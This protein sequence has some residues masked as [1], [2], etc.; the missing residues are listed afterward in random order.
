MTG[1]RQRSGREGER[2]GGREGERAID[3]IRSWLRAPLRKDGPGN[4][5]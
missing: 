3:I 2:E 5:S 1:A 4:G